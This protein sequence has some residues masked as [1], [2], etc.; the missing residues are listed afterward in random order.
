[1]LRATGTA[2]DHR[3]LNILGSWLVASERQNI[4]QNLRAVPTLGID[5]IAYHPATKFIERQSSILSG[6]RNR[7]MTSD[8]PK[9]G[10]Q[11]SHTRPPVSFVRVSPSM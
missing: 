1:M 11:V 8:I 5:E 10:V 4:A 6:S 3:R 9:S 7:S 2:F